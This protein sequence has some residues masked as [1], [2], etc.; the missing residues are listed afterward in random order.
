MAHA[1]DYEAQN[2]EERFK[3]NVAVTSNDGIPRFVE[4]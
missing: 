1:P 3:I 2:F 4:A